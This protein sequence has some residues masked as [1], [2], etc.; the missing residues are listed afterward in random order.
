MMTRYCADVLPQKETGPQSYSSNWFAGLESNSGGRSACW[1]PDEN[2]RFEDALAEVDADSPDRWEKVASLIPGKTVADVMNH[3]GELVDDVSDIEA[4]RIPY[5][6]YYGASSFTLDWESS[7][8]SEEWNN[9]FCNSGKRSCVRG[10]DHERKKGVPWTEDE[11]KLFLLGLKKYGKGDWRNISRNFVIT[12]TPTQ[13]ASHA[14]K[15]FIRLNT[16]SKDKRRSSIHDIT[17]VDLPN[18]NRPTSPS[19]QPSTITS[20]SSLG[21]TPPLPSCQLS[22]IVDSDQLG[23]VASG[24]N[25]SLR[26]NQFVQNQ[27]GINPSYMKLRSQNPQLMDEILLGM[28][29]KEMLPV[30]FSMQ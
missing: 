22:V 9:S 14:Q 3:Y 7:Y 11:H 26:E 2:K 20:Q 13:V 28:A 27:L 16:G 1:T 18:N 29:S 6:E 24:F 25:P 4:G 21:M 30:G 10:S 8:D 23:E 15:Y 19:T 17:T 5:P 12:R